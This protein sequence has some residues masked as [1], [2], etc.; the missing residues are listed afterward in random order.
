[1]IGQTILLGSHG[2]WFALWLACASHVPWNCTPN[3]AHFVIK[4]D[5][6]AIAETCGEWRRLGYPAFP[7]YVDGYNFTLACPRK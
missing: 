1:M 2:P 3:T 6:A 7:A 5:A 4:A